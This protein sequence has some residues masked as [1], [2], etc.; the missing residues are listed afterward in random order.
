MIV[1]KGT[2]PTY[3]LQNASVIIYEECHRGAPRFLKC[4]VSDLPSLLLQEKPKQRRKTNTNEIHIMATDALADLVN[5]G[6]SS[7]RTMVGMKRG[8]LRLDEGDLTS[9]PVRGIRFGPKTLT[10]RVQFVQVC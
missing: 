4:V 6:G 5:S 3:T 8:N 9:H 1:K 10:F 7:G 2:L